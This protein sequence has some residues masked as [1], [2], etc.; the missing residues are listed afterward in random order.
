MCLY[1]LCSWMQLSYWETDSTGSGSSALLGTFRVVSHLRLISLHFLGKIFL[2]PRSTR[3][4]QNYEFSHFG[5]RHC[6]SRHVN[7][8]Y[9]PFHLCKWSFLPPWVVFSQACV[10]WYLQ[11]TKEVQSGALWSTLSVQASPICILSCKL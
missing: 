1:R 3:W 5:N 4:T 9:D 7:T 2:G 10:Y 11:N 8:K 6:V